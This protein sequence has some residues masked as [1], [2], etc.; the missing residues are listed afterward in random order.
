MRLLMNSRPVL[1]GVTLTSLLLSGC[2]FVGDFDDFY[3]PVSKA[4]TYEVCYSNADCLPGD[5]CEELA[6]PAIESL[7]ELVALQSVFRMFENLSESTLFIEPE[8]SLNSGTSKVGVD[9]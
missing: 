1:L 7:R 5:Y 6:L 2:I 4:I 3:E 8:Q 9:Q